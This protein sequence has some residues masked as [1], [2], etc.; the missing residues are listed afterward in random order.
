MNNIFSGVVGFRRGHFEMSAM[1]RE[2]HDQDATLMLR[3]LSHMFRER[4]M[5]PPSFTYARRARPDPRSGRCCRIESHA[6]AMAPAPS[7]H[8]VAA[9]HTAAATS[10]CLERLWQCGKYVWVWRQSAGPAL[11][12]GRHGQLRVLLQLRGPDSADSGNCAAFRAVHG[13]STAALPA[14]LQRRR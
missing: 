14:T 7:A 1:S 2:V 9:A 12:E 11:R 3:P 4:K 13:C 8:T 5:L 10:R 6:E